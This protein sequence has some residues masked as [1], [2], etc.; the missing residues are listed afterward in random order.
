MLP[1]SQ[2]RLRYAPGAGSNP[3]TVMN[4][5]GPGIRR[6]SDTNVIVRSGPPWGGTVPVDRGPVN[7]F[8]AE[9][10]PSIF[11]DSVSEAPSA[12]RIHDYRNR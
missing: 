12:G 2:F 4:A 9:G 6:P 11:G 8:G 5:E 3:S 10:D 1:G 7:Q